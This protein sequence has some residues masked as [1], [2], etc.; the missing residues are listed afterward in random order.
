MKSVILR[1]ENLQRAFNTEYGTHQVL[2]GISVDFYRGDF[3]VIMGESGSGKSTLLYSLSGL[4]IP[5]G[6]SIYFGESNLT[7]MNVNQLVAYRKNSCGFVFQQDC[8]IQGLSVMDNVLV[9]GLLCS[10]DRKAVIERAEKLFDQVEITPITRTKF[11]SQISGG[12]AQRVGIVRALINS[13]ELLFADEPTGALN[14]KVSNEV[15]DIFTHF[16]RLGQTII[17]VTHDIKSALRAN[18][19]LYLK[20][21]SIE[22]ELQLDPYTADTPERIMKTNEFLESMRW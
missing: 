5:T 2:N 20:D 13:P 7:K 12:H 11:P 21:G 1:T 14:S 6:G 10:R 19:I 3:T 8:L 18:R 9:S 22:D 17:M 16:N 15:L 4:D